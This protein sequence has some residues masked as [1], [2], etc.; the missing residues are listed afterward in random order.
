MKNKLMECFQEY[1]N[2]VFMEMKDPD[3]YTVDFIPKPTSGWKNK[4][5]IVNLNHTQKIWFEL[6]K[7]LNKHLVGRHPE[8]PNKRPHLLH[9]FNS[10]E[11]YHKTK[12][13][14]WIKVPPHLHSV[15]FVHPKMQD[16]FKELLDV[17]SREYVKSLINN[18]GANYSTPYTIR[19]EVFVGEY[20]T[21]IKDS[22]RSLEIRIPYNL[23]GKVDYSF[24]LFENYRP[25]HPEDVFK[26]D[27]EEK[28]DGMGI[29]VLPSEHDFKRKI[30]VKPLGEL[31]EE[32]VSLGLGAGVS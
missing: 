10:F 7:L 8:R 26:H 4:S 30:M 3:I 28:L 29:F 24:G 20:G 9:S 18:S 1:S 6:N 17:D 12:K 2:Q 14:E 13:Q 21:E 19:P 31:E 23:E 22:I 25:I 15:M 5:N 32:I 27:L 16:R 11:I